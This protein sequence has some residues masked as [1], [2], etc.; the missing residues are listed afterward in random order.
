VTVFGSTR[1]MAAT[2]AGVSSG[3]DSG[4]RVFIA[5]LPHNWFLRGIR[6]VEY[7]YLVWHPRAGIGASKL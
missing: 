4:G 6:E 1:N 7:L 2:S 3:S 5:G